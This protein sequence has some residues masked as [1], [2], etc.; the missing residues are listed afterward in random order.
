MCGVTFKKQVLMD[1]IKM[2]IDRIVVMR[3]FFTV[4]ISVGFTKTNISN[5]MN[6]LLVKSRIG[7]I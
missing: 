6:R 7:A 1:G 5:S 3:L 2:G 4:L